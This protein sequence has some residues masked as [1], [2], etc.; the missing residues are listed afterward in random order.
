MDFIGI[1][2]TVADIETKLG[3]LSEEK[4]SLMETVLVEGSE[5]EFDVVHHLD[6]LVEFVESYSDV[7]AQTIAE[8]V[9]GGEVLNIVLESVRKNASDAQAVINE[10]VENVGD[11]DLEV[12]EE[13]N[14]TVSVSLL[15]V[16]SNV[17]TEM[18]GEEGVEGMPAEMVFDIVNEAKELDLSDE[19]KD[20][21][22]ESL[23]SEVSIKLEESIKSGKIDFDS[24][25]YEGETLAEFLD[26]YESTED[27][28]EEMSK[29]NAEVL[30]ES[31]NED[32]ARLMGKAKQATTLLEGTRCAKGDIKCMEKKG[33]LAKAFFAKGGEMKGTKFSPKGVLNIT[34]VTGK[35][36]KIL[37]SI[38]KNNPR[39]P[40]VYL[41]NVVMPAIINKMAQ[42]K[43]KKRKTDSMRKRA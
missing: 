13:L 2:E 30:A 19:A 39:Y 5:I 21:D 9:D 41:R 3:K 40:A 26:D 8:T 11:M 18:V 7:Q 15:S 32:G 20:M 43:G 29:V 31:D 23:I 14:E 27:L 37:R 38:K 22:I 42:K 35:L 17:L 24:D 12:A 16:V 25:D 10:A 33:K 28:M 34:K 36:G 6:H 1:V 4:L